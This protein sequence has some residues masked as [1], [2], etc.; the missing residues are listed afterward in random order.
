[1][2]KSFIVPIIPPDPPDVGCAPGVGADG[3]VGDVGLNE[4]LNEALPKIEVPE[5]AFATAI[6]TVDKPTPTATSVWFDG[7]GM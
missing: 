5:K 1:M 6:P 7:L 4:P 3:T 2:K